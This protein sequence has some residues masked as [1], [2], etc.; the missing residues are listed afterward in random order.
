MCWGESAGLGV[1]IYLY[2]SLLT[3]SLIVL[4]V[5]A[6]LLRLG[7]VLLHDVVV[8]QGL[9]SEQ[10]E[11]SWRAHDTPDHMFGGLLQP[12]ADSVLEELVPH[13]GA[14]TNRVDTSA[15]SSK[16]L[17]SGINNKSVLYIK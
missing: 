3:S 6:R 15:G 12:M 9:G 17:S 1:L 14:G 8:H 10:G 7:G 13:H 4:Y 5:V 11:T 2:S 16:H